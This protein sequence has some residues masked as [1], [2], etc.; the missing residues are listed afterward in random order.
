MRWHVVFRYAGVAMLLNAAFLIVSGALALGGSGEDAF[1]LLYSGALAALFGGFPLIFVPPPQ[2]ISNGEGLVT[3]T[4]AW[5]LSCLVGALPYV[6]WGGEFTWSNAWFESV[7]GYTTTGASIL[8]D[9][10]GLPPALLFWRAATHWIGGIGIIVFVLAVLPAQGFSAWVLYRTATPAEV[11]EKLRYRTR[12]AVQVLLTVYV[13]LTAL[14]IVLLVAFGMGLLD[15]VAHAFATIATGGF[16]TRNASV[17]AFD[18]LAIEIVCIVF[19]VLSGLHFGLLFGAVAGRWRDLWRSAATRL[20][21]ASLAAGTAVAAVALGAV[22]SLREAAFQVVSVGTST[23]L[24]TADSSVWPPLA[25][26]ALLYLTFQCACMGSTS[27]GIK[28]DR[29]VLFGSSLAR[30]V[31]RLRHPAAVVRVRMDGRAVDDD[32]V[33]A[34]VLY[35][36]LYVVIVFAGSLLLVPMGMDPLSA[37]SGCA[38]AMGN[39]GPGLG[40]VGSLENFG[41]VPDAGKWILTALMLLGRLEVYGLVA[42]LLPRAWRW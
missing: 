3:V 11:R 19:M 38:A 26:L 25:Q 8:A 24:A 6:L 33:E 13:G 34:A 22:G 14:Q 28:V 17:A 16:S 35:I 30:T 36:V 5:L 4:T 23:G 2:E 20:Y 21:V 41:H 9:V 12:K 27:G 29:L 37:F 31:K 40:T 39:V 18:S 32:A 1:P 10:E 15:A 7:S 42:L